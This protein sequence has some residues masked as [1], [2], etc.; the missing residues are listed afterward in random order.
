[1]K[2]KKLL[3]F[4]GCILLSLLFM[5]PYLSNELSLEHD[6]LFHLSRIEGLAQSFQSGKLFPDIYPLKNDGFG[7]ASA[8]FYCDFF[9][10]PAAFL[11]NLG[12]G[13]ALCYK[14]TV[15]L[16]TL[17]SAWSMAMLLYRTKHSGITS[18]LA[19][20]LYL[21]CNYRISDVYV[22]GALGEV[23]ALSFIPFILL[24]AYELFIKKKPKIQ[25]LVI[26]FT[27]VALS[28]NLSLLLSGVGFA[29]LL[30]FNIKHMNKERWIALIQAALISIGLSAWFLFP[31]LEQTSFQQY[32]LHYYA[33]SSDLATHAMM[34]WQY[35]INQ[36]IF[37]ISSNSLSA[38]EAMVVTPGLFLL[39]LPVL[40][41]FDVQEKT[42]RDRF[43]ITCCLMGYG[44]AFF[45]SDIFPWEHMSLLRIMQF[46][47]RVMTL[48]CPLL[49]FASA[50]AL[51][52][53]NTSNLVKGM[54]LMSVCMNAIFLLLPACN[55]TLVIQ[56]DTTYEELMNG[57]II[58]PYY[59]NTSY[60]RIEVAGADYLPIGFLDYKNASHC[61]TDLSGNEISCPVQEDDILSFRAPERT[62]II[63]PLTAY[64]GYHVYADNE[65]I[66]WKT[67]EG[68]ISFN[69]DQ[70]K[71]FSIMYKKT[72]IHQISLA[73]SLL[74]I[75]MIL[76]KKIA[77]SATYKRRPLNDFREQIQK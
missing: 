46:P 32:Y 9:L 51:Q 42:N 49:A 59:A 57:S 19:S 5:F 27:G 56:N 67:V 72:R 10:I 17:L 4:A 53:L 75:V 13:V 25:T 35:L 54:V 3:I 70:H 68:R 69:T 73:I 45:A 22:R 40:L 23:I 16:A 47:W 63:V 2:Q 28:H 29:M 41:L 34:S 7:Y 58:D 15:F 18:L 11:Y 24:G 43:I 6:T 38:S 71:F 31:M 65:E 62:E 39:F 14:T 76:L 77:K 37:G 48:A 12:C 26:G 64:K 1:M 21:F 50:H 44:F 33:S 66:D 52:K 20:A 8:L 55:R 60:N 36:T 74:S 30:L 61:V